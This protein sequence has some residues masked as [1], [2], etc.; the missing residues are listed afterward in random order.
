MFC[1]TRPIESIQFIVPQRIVLFKEL[2]NDDDV[3]DNLPIWLAIT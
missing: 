2:I 3:D 1:S